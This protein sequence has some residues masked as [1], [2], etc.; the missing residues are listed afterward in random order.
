[1]RERLQVALRWLV[2]RIKERSGRE[3]AL[4][5]AGVFAA[6]LVLLQ[7]GAV[8]PL[9]AGLAAAQDDAERAEKD[10]KQVAV[11]APELQRLRVQLGQV[12]QRIQPGDQTNLL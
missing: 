8:N 1:M 12:E 4:L 5:A 11:L 7:L 9:R 10:L 2:A 3:Q 6:L